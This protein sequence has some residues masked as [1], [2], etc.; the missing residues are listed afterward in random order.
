[1]IHG[2]EGIDVESER[3]VAVA[4]DG[5]G[6]VFFFSGKALIKA[7]VQIS[8][9]LYRF[10]FVFSEID[11]DQILVNNAGHWT[12]MST[13]KSFYLVYLRVATRACDPEN[14]S[15]LVLIQRPYSN[16][17]KSRRLFQLCV[18]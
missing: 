17:K 8:N 9:L 12:S 5:K 15:G 13:H 2:G 7:R 16:S 6:A 4:T 10:A 3:F 18:R 1:M 14:H 11:Y